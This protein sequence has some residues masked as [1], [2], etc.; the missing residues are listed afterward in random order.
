[1]ARCHTEINNSICSGKVECL[2][3]RSTHQKP[4]GRAVPDC[5][6]DSSSQQP[7][8]DNPLPHYV[9]QRTNSNLLTIAPQIMCI[10]FGMEENRQREHSLRRSSKVC[11]T[12]RGTLFMDGC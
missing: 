2:R 4:D 1:M 7:R 12:D 3:S 11:V 6:A 5:H 8:F 9:E 10:Y